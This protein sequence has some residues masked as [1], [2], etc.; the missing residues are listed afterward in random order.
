MF[1]TLYLF[2]N[3]Y[4]GLGKNFADHKIKRPGYLLKKNAD[5][6]KDRLKGVKILNQDWKTVLKKYASAK[7]F[8]FI[9]PPYENESLKGT[10]IYKPFSPKQLI[11][12]L[13]KLKGKFLLTFENSTKNK[14]LFKQAGFKIKT[15]QT[16][17]SVDPTGSSKKRELIV[18]N[19]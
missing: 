11:P 2:K 14:Q 15:I 10:W 12:T 17:Y 3:S 18:T 1:K 6:Y 5:K 7:S 13:K 19:Y 16:T 8:T 9:D 4:G